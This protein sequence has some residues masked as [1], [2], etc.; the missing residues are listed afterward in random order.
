MSNHKVSEAVKRHLKENYERAVNMWLLELLNMWEF[1]SAYGFWVGDDVGGTYCYGDDL[2]FQ[3]D[4]IIFCVMNDVEEKEYRE[5]MDYNSW[6][7]EFKQP[8][9]KLKAW[10]TG[11]PRHSKETM[12]RLEGLKRELETLCDE[13]SKEIGKF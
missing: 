3:M 11:C 7:I 8:T 13:C 12:D 4:D 9:I 2:F 1:D 10:H 5:W 6:A